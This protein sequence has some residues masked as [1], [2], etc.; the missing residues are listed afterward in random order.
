[1]IRLG[2]S[3]WPSAAGPKC[4]LGWM[5]MMQ[6]MQIQLNRMNVHPKDS[7]S[8]EMVGVP[9]RYLQIFKPLQLLSD[10]FLQLPQA[11]WPAS[12]LFERPRELFKDPLTFG[13]GRFVQ[14]FSSLNFWRIPSDFICSDLIGLG[15]YHFFANPPWGCCT[16]RILGPNWRFYCPR[17]RS[18]LSAKTGFPLHCT[19]IW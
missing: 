12:H 8:F 5:M 16:R 3:M 2:R 11:G 4:T 6:P 1:M 18:G 7:S 10:G 15:Q 14:T 13:R 19:V 17:S 9:S